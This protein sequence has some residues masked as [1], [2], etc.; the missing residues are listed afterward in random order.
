MSLFFYG[1]LCHAAVLQRVIGHEGQGLT[2]RDALLLDHMRLHVKGEDYP[3]VVSAEKA[4]Q[5]VD[6]SLEPDEAR[7]QGVLVQGLSEADILLLDE[8][9]GDEYE[10]SPCTVSLFSSDPTSAPLQSTV[11]LWTAP[12]S[13]L[14]PRLWSF[15]DFLRDSAHRWVGTGPDANGYYAEVDRTR[16]MKGVITPSGVKEE[17][18]KVLA[19]ATEQLSLDANGHQNGQYESFGHALGK[20]YW[21]FGDDWINLN[22][23]SYGAAPRPVVDA[24]HAIQA[25]CD[26]A[27][28]RFIR[29][30][31]EQELIDL[32]A[33]LAESVDCDTD[34][35]VLVANATSGVN[36]ALRALTTEW[37]KGDR[38]LYF[39]SSIYNACQASMQYIVDTHPHLDLELLPVTFTYPKSHAEVVRLA[40]EA[41]DAANS[42][43][44]GRKVRLALVD[45]ISSLPG[46]IVPWE[47]LVELFHEKGVIALVDG[48]HQ[49]GQLPVSIRKTKPDFFVSNAHKWLHAHRGVAIFYADKK[50]QHLVHSSPIGHYY[51]SKGGFVNEHSWSG[52][53]DW[54]P[55]L[56]V[57]AALDFRRDVLGGEERIRKYCHELAVEGG[58]LVAK[59]LGTSVLRNPNPEDGE[60]IANMVNVELP[61]PAPSTFAV[62]DLQQLTPW[63]FRHFIKKHRF[64]PPLYMHNDKFY[65]RLS[66]QVYNELSDF[67]HAAQALQKGCE[68]VRAGG[69]Q[70][71][72]A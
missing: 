60:L 71:G 50:W 34:D 24:L 45:S 59:A 28:D 12:L 49:V 41:I 64:S 70:S 17:S 63:W 22:H 68:A 58:E 51:G 6:R 9:E 36:E 44:T 40:R 19:G 7:V 20:K 56:S 4:S 32:R 53:V 2:T 14:E 55:Y 15:S 39:S 23:G 48:A 33:R 43:G 47:E 26:S 61:L 27:P 69:W 13:R 54:S 52:T 65:T 8:F 31:Y 29:V 3:A 35:L 30:E 21:R 11:Y 16:N 67:E 62:S 37:N 72:S 25:R 66:A 38:L 46:V 1:T 57:A 10:R 18:E 42:D 5:L